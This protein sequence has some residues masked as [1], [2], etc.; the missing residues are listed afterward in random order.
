VGAELVLAEAEERWRGGP[1][2]QPTEPLS[3]ARRFLARDHCKIVGVDGSYAS[4][5]GIC[6]AD[7][8]LERSSET[9]LI[10]RDTA[11][12]VR[13]PAV[14]NVERALAGVWDLH[15]GPLPDE[16]RPDAVGIPLAGEKA[17]RVVIQES[18][19]ARVLRTLEILLAAADKRMWIANAYFLSAP[20]L[21][22]ALISAAC[23]SVDVRILLPPMRTGLY[24]EAPSYRAQHQEQEYPPPGRILVL[25][26]PGPA[27]QASGNG[28]SGRSR[29]LRRG[30]AGSHA[31]RFGGVAGRS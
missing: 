29:T 28:R 2:R 19:R 5:G 31:P 25:S 6:I 10:Y 20:T 15:G 4:V 12:K 13:G 1:R 22:Q 17:T 3:G 23:D 16:E 18:G 7:G 26:R 27:W 11:T 21:T 9:G 24:G 30:L 14:A 8:W